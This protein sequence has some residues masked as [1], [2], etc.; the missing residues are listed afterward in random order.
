V[1]DP[2]FEQFCDP[3]VPLRDRHDAGML[4]FYAGTVFDDDDKDRLVQLLNEPHAAVAE[5]AWNLLAQSDNWVV[6]GVAHGL[7][8]RCRSS[9]GEQMAHRDGL[10]DA[11]LGEVVDL[12][13]IGTLSDRLAAPSTWLQELRHKRI[14]PM[15]RRW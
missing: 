4:L 13:D 11:D 2:L 14:T 9:A 8:V 6:V 12:E 7:L 5:L 3:D 1:A 10:A 15:R